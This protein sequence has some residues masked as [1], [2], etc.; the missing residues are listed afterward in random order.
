MNLQEEKLEI[1]KWL[2]GIEDR[3][4][5]NQFIFLKNSNLRTELTTQEKNAIDVALKSVDEGRIKS[6]EEVLKATKSK[7]PQLFK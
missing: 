1:I 2:V 5:I 4:L 3:A 7:F 6:H